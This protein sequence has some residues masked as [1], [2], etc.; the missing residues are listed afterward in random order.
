MNLARRHF[1]RNQ[2]KA[3]AE[4][5]A[6]YGSMQNASSYELQ[7]AQLANDKHRLKQLQGLELKNELKAKLIEHHLPYVDGVLSANAGV[8]DEVVT[9]TLVWCLDLRKYAKALQIG[10]YALVHSLVMPDAFKRTVACILTEE[11]AENELKR[12]KQNEPIDTDA[13]HALHDLLGD[14]NLPATARDMP[15]EVR[16]KL[17]LVIGR[18]YLAQAKDG[19]GGADDAVDALSMALALHDKCGCKS[20]LAQAKKLAAA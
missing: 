14:E 11:L 20:D 12:Q 9:T 19:R 8:Q 7:L 13:L 6:E 16:A 1:L 10:R 2:A 17:Y 18:H 4:R 5:A 15:D 3:D